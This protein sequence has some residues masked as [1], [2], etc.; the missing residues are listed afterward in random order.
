MNYFD[1]NVIELTNR[2]RET[3]LCDDINYKEKLSNKK[4]NERQKVDL[5]LTLNGE[6][7]WIELK[8]ILVGY[9]IKTP[10]SLSFYF[11]DN[12][13][14]ANDIEKL[15]NVCHLDKNLHL[16]SLVFV[17]TNYDKEGGKES[18]IKE[19][20]ET[21]YDLKNKLDHFFGNHLDLKDKILN[22]SYDYNK[23]LHFGYIIL[24][25]KKGNGKISK[26]NP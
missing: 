4:G 25:V 12:S 26:I 24:E 14:I 7:Y 18:K 11:S 17:S 21:S 10:I 3:P 2:N 20:I 13:Y 8:H 23:E 5:K 6:D 19:K 15:R 9:Q 1:G 22:T 16:Y